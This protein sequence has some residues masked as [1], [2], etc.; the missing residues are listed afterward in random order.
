MAGPFE[1]VAIYL[2]REEWAELTGWQ[3]RLYREVMLDTYEMVASLG[4]VT[5]KPD[6]ICKLE[7]GQTPC[8]PDPPGALQRHRSPVPG[9]SQASVGRS[10]SS[11]RH[12]AGSPEWELSGS[13]GDISVHPHLH[14]V[15]D[16][17][18]LEK[19]PS[20]CNKNLRG[21]T[22][23]AMQKRSQ[24]GKQPFSCTDCGKSFRRKA[25]LTEHQR[26]HTGERPFAC[27]HCDKRF[28]YKASLLTH[29]RI[30]TGER[31]FACADCGKSFREKS[32]LISHQ[33]IHTAEQPFAC[34][35][36]GKSFRQKR[37]LIS[38]Q[39]IHTGERPFACT[40]CGES[41]SRKGSLIRHQH[42][43]TSERPLA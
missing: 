39:R 24:R 6:I 15:L 16:P 4:W 41:F 26:I 36:C 13:R 28:R 17:Q 35:D 12:G 40:D 30:H 1:E 11:S 9:V 19:N 34:A 25:K 18:Q 31:P 27:A 10:R 23:L 21:R 22:A 20:K 14:D 3:R 2:C 29:Q 42:I 38:H 43:H 32:S 33:R 7:R 37:S 5:I 8:V